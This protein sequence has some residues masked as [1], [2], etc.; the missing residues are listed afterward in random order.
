VLARST[1]RWAA[2]KTVRGFGIG[3]TALISAQSDLGRIDA[4]ARVE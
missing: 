2:P 4:S 3:G 1:M